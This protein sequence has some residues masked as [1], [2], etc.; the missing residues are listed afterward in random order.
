MNIFILY[1]C[2]RSEIA[3]SIFINNADSETAIKLLLHIQLH[4]S[5]SNKRNIR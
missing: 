4:D 5:E 3:M 2:Y 1:L